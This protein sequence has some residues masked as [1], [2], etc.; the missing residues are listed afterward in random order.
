M[1]KKLVQDSEGNWYLIDPLDS[2][3]FYQLDSSG[4]YADFNNCFYEN[5]IDSP[6]GLIIDVEEEK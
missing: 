5:M 1:K 3:L 2:E 4:S 6:V